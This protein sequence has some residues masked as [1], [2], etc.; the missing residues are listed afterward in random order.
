MPRNK[1]TNRQFLAINPYF[2]VDNVYK[3]AEYYRD[4]LGFHFDQFWGNPPSFVMLRR[5]GIQIMLRQPGEL[6][7]SVLKPNRAIMPHSFDAYVYVRD[8]DALYEELKEKGAN[9]LYE[10]CDQP[11]DCREFEAEDV[12]GYILCFG[13]DLLLGSE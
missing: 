1:S 10:P 2:L 8:V 7:T 5:E 3:S 4:V 13:Q 9:L 6:T 12:N 11:H